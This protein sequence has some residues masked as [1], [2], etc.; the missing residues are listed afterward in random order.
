MRPGPSGARWCRR[1]SP[2]PEPN[3]RRTVRARVGCPSPV[4]PRV[5]PSRRQS[6]RSAHGY[7]GDPRSISRTDRDSRP[8]VS[9]PRILPRAHRW[10]PPCRTA[11]PFRPVEHGTPSSARAA[12]C[13]ADPGIPAARGRRLE[14]EG[15]LSRKGRRGSVKSIRA[16]RSARGG[17]GAPLPGAVSARPCAGPDPGGQ[18]PFAAAEPRM[19][20]PSV[21][22]RS[23]FPPSR[24]ESP[25]ESPRG[26]KGE[27]PIR[28][29]AAARPPTAARRPCGCGFR[30]L[31]LD[32]A[33]KRGRPGVAH[34]GAN[35]AGGLQGWAL[36]RRLPSAMAAGA[37]APAARLARRS[38]PVPCAPRPPTP[39]G[40]HRPVG[41]QR[42]AAGSSARRRRR[43][44]SPHPAAPRARGD[45]PGPTPQRPLRLRPGRCVGGGRG[46]PDAW[47]LRRRTGRTPAPWRSGPTGR[48]I[49]APVD[50]EP[51]V[52]A[53]GFA[54]RP[55]EHGGERPG[56]GRWPRP[57][58]AATRGAPFLLSRLVGRPRGRRRPHAARSPPRSPS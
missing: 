10:R 32:R 36:A 21:A 52:V 23:R 38:R 34:N 37:R 44:R 42:R 39:D 20:A 3:A 29:L 57:R 22:W 24:H 2:P 15:G 30:P 48:T 45:Q 25:W 50:P 16:T 9:R 18:D 31:N 46:S 13:A 55:S 8:L 19:P 28:G 6:R 40:S 54:R 56:G 14:G 11:G 7:R 47:R 5:E 1:P 58:R 35:V 27:G 4:R 43:R 26:S 51:I 41:R 53:H 17:T 12:P 33:A 49:S